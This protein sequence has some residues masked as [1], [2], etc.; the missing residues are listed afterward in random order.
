MNPSFDLRL[1]AMIRVLDTAVLPAVNDS[2]ARH[3][4]ALVIGHLRVLREQLDDGPRHDLLEF[5]ASRELALLLNQLI[6]DQEEMA[7]ELRDLQRALQ[8]GE[9]ED[10]RAMRDARRALEDAVERAV[11][12]SVRIP[13]AD[14]RSTIRRLVVKHSREQAMRARIFF[15]GMGFEFEPMESIDDMLSRLAAACP[16]TDGSAHG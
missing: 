6:I 5:R 3:L 4:G 13:L 2:M 14:L 16:S 9:T 11:R 1:A 7:D 8:F 15:G 10:V 12:A